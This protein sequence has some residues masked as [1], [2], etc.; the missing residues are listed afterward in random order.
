MNYVCK[1]IQRYKS[2]ESLETKLG[3][4]FSLPATIA[5]RY[6]KKEFIK[7]G[8]FAGY[9]RFIPKHLVLSQVSYMSETW[10]KGYM[11]VTDI[12][13]GE[14][15]ICRLK[16]EGSGIILVALRDLLLDSGLRVK[17]DWFRKKIVEQH[18]EFMLENQ[19]S[20]EKE[21]RPAPNKKSPVYLLA[22][23][24]GKQKN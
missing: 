8:E 5:D 24:L 3:N 4:R 6:P 12:F 17:K 14:D 20:R 15:N 13:I 18:K 7:Q 16:V 2:S 23:S 21:S 1:I 11:K 19:L 22:T 9:C 10:T